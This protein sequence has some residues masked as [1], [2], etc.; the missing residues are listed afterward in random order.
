MNKEFNLNNR[1]YHWLLSYFLQN[2]E[3]VNLVGFSES[4]VS[5]IK[6][7]YPNYNYNYGTGNF[8]SIKNNPSFWKNDKYEEHTL[9]ICTSGESLNNW[10]VHLESHFSSVAIFGLLPFNNPKIILPLTSRFSTNLGLNLHKPGRLKARCAIKIASFLL[11]FGNL[12]LLKKN[13]LIV[14]TNKSTYD[15][16]LGDSKIKSLLDLLTHNFVFY[17]GNSS[18]CEKLISLST[19]RKSQNFIFKITKKESD[20]GLENEANSLTVLSSSTIHNNIPKL[21]NKYCIAQKNIYQYSFRQRVFSF[22]YGLFNNSLSFLTQLSKLDRRC[23]SFGEIIEKYDPCK[24]SFQSSELSSLCNNLYQLLLSTTP[25]DLEVVF[26]RVHGD[27]A[28]WNFSLTDSGFFVY[29]W[30]ESM[31]QGLALSD[32]IYMQFSKYFH[33]DNSFKC[34][35][36]YK[37]KNF[38]LKL[39]GNANIDGNIYTYMSLWFLNYAKSVNNNNEFLIYFG[40]KLSKNLNESTNFSVCM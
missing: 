17:L 36:F 3:E 9:F 34:F 23:I 18:N 28:P 20:F 40:R 26:H 24:F 37:I 39:S 15:R 14:A 31:S 30:E 16:L 13:I 29:D 25:F 12:S 1:I 19:Y 35:A 6:Q 2:N 32:A 5:F 4:E 8:I 33:I 22:Q 21:I 38:C 11:L 27:Y 7:N 10:K